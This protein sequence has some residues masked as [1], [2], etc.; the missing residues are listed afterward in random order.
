MKRVKLD[1]LAAKYRLRDY[2]ELYAKILELIDSNQIKPVKASGINGKS[3]ALYREYWIIEESQDLTK[4]L[5][6]LNFQIVIFFLD[7]LGWR[8]NNL[9]LGNLCGFTLGSCHIII[10]FYINIKS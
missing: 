7:V 9:G 8:L 10:S 6:E 2:K 5:D 1:N 4:Y 3:P